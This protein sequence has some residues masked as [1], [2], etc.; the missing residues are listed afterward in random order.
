MLL[1]IL[2]P[3]ILREVTY[4]I[5]ELGEEVSMLSL[6][7]SRASLSSALAACREEMA[8][9]PVLWYWVANQVV[10][11]ASFGELSDVLNR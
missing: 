5:G 7:P 8:F 3:F 11:P 4:L 10:L 2:Q 6:A 1:S 9:F